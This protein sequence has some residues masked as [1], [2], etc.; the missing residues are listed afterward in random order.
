MDVVESASS[1]YILVCNGQRS[2]AEQSE[3]L[4]QRVTGTGIAQDCDHPDDYGTSKTINPM[5]TII[6]ASDSGARSPVES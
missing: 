6:A 2:V 5:M 1:A 4:G 3:I